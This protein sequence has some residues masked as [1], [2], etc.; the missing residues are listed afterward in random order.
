MISCFRGWVKNTWKIKKN[1]KTIKII[2]V[3]GNMLTVSCRSPH[4]E[5]AYDPS[6][7][8]PH[9]IRSQPLKFV[10]WLAQSM[11]GFSQITRTQQIFCH[12]HL[13]YLWSKIYCHY[14]KICLMRIFMTNYFLEKVQIRIINHLLCDSLALSRTNWPSNRW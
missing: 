6:Y 8:T 4:K 14:L 7:Q 12:S 9:E 5:H 11:I 2:V 1:H 3:I 10:S 13:V